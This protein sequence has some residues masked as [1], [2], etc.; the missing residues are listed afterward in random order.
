MEI[1]AVPAAIGPQPIPDWAALRASLEA[2][3]AA[4][5]QLLDAAAGDRWRARSS[6][7]AWTVGEVLV[8]LTWALEYLPKEVA[9]AR[10]GKG[11][12]NMPKWF[13]DPAS[14]WLIRWQARQS[15][16]EA[17]RRRYDAAMDAAVAAL[18]TVPDSDW[19]LGAPFYGHGFYTVAALFETPAQHLAEHTGR[20]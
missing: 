4:F 16:P 7:S 10:Q 9:M 14:Y 3:R 17:L 5:H 6:T 18:E 19:G 12:F 13:A 2:T 8:H 15:N 20:P 11:M 1:H